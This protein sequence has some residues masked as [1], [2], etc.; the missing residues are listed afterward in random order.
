[1]KTVRGWM[2]STARAM[3]TL[4]LAAAAASPGTAAAYPGKPVRIVVPISPGSATDVVVRVVAEKLSAAL[5]QPVVVENRPGAGTTLAAAAVARE[6]ADGHTLLANS[7][8]HTV[9]PWIYPKLPYD[10]ERDFAPVATLASL[11]NV[12]VV[13]AA[14]GL[15]SVQD[16]LQAARAQPLALNYASAGTGTSTHLAAEKFRLA[17]GIAAT[18]VPYKGTP[19]ALAATVAGDVDFFFAPV[20][21]V[22]P[23]IKTGALLALAVSGSS[24]APGLPNL[25]RL[26]DAGVPGADAE[27]WIGLFAPKGTPAAVVER[28][29]R[30]VNAILARPEVAEKLTTLGATPRSMSASSFGALVRSDLQAHRDLVRAAG[31]KAD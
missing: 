13:P 5:K 16:V 23:H 6:Q 31:L 28:L 4:L 11:P 26:A 25:R 17:T 7:T 27:F 22:L 14:K 15:R 1:M 21:S 20:S 19:E 12:L 18:H 24:P 3:A 8:A 30:E 9:V 10:A 2:E 29:N